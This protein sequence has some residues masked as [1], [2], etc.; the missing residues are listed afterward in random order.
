MPGIFVRVLRAEQIP[1]R[2]RQPE[3]GLPWGVHPVLDLMKMVLLIA[4]T[5]RDMARL[6]TKRDRLISIMAILW[7]VTAVGLVLTET[8]RWLR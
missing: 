5:Q 8:L 4:D 7:C 1:P 3:D 6:V 2:P